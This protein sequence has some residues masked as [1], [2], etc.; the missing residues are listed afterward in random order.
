M[1]LITDNECWF[2]IIGPIW[3]EDDYEE[4]FLFIETPKKP[5]PITIRRK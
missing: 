4:E 3:D 5:K 1:E 2:G